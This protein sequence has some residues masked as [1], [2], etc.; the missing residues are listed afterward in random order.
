M[1]NNQ[2]RGDGCHQDHLCLLQ[3]WEESSSSI[4]IIIISFHP[5]LHCFDLSQRGPAVRNGVRLP[6]RP[7]LLKSRELCLTSTSTTDPKSTCY[8]PTYPTPIKPISTSSNNNHFFSHICLFPDLTHCKDEIFH[9]TTR[10]SIHIPPLLSFCA[11]KSS[12]ETE[13]HIRH[14]L[15]PHTHPST[16][17][18][19]SH[20]NLSPICLAHHPHPTP[21]MMSS[22]QWL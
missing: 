13:N 11:H 16:I 18:T 1:R 15:P 12:F 14:H 6:A 4:T 2:D 7:N 21:N 9:K 10:P 5:D 22:H 8:A 19:P 17:H 20:P 3:V